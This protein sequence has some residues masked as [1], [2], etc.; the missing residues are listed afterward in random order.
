MAFKGRPQMLSSSGLPASVSN[1]PQII[2]FFVDLNPLRPHRAAGLPVRL[3]ASLRAGLPAGLRFAIRAASLA[4]LLPPLLTLAGCS[5]LHHDLH[6]HVYVSARQVYLHDRVAAVSNRVAQVDNGQALEVIEHGRRFFHVKTP[7]NQIGWIE[8]HAVIDQKLYDQFQQLTE[9]HKKDPTISTATLRDDLYLHIHPGR[10]SEHFYLLA[11]N[12]KVQLLARRSI[13]KGSSNLP[14]LPGIPLKPSSHAAPSTVNG[15]SGSPV[16]P[17]TDREAS[18]AAAAAVLPPIPLED[19]WL[20]RDSSGHAGWLLSGRVDVDVPDEIGI[21]AEGQRIVGAYVLAKVNDPNSSTPDKSVPEYVTLLSPPKSGLPYDFDQVRVF[22]WSMTHHRY[23]TA[24]RLHPIAGYL[25]LRLSAQSVPGRN[26]S[27]R[28]PSNDAAAP[29][30]P[31][32]SFQIANSSDISADVAT[33]LNRPAS[34]RT[35]TYQ[36]IDTRVLRIGPDLAPIPSNRRPDNKDKSG[37]RSSAKK[38]HRP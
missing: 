22:T 3:R 30:A 15:A 5:R 6:E 17:Q 16:S 8:E 13:V 12:S 29:T 35:L 20:V 32:F 34:L 1:Y 24:F 36:M 23:E 21:Y 4:L 31:V 14:G 10:D 9:E 7:K 33:G 38:K 27:S 26:A 11:G 37:D 2:F 19:W 28:I 18:S 25:P